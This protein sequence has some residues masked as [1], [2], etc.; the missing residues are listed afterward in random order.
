M[1]L[2]EDLAE[3][4]KKKHKT[5]WKFDKI[6]MVVPRLHPKPNNEET[7]EIIFRHQVKWKTPASFFINI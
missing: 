2:I 3:A 7:T 5:N 1:S 4:E 6:M